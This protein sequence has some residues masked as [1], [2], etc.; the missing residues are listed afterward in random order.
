MTPYQL[1]EHLLAARR[2]RRAAE[3]YIEALARV[4]GVGVLLFDVDRSNGRMARLSCHSVA[5][6]DA[7]AV[8]RVVVMERDARTGDLGVVVRRC[9][10]KKLLNLAAVWTRSP[11]SGLWRLDADPSGETCVDHGFR[12]DLRSHAGR[13]R[14]LPPFRTNPEPH[15]ARSAG[16]VFLWSMAP[17]LRD[18]LA[19]TGGLLDVRGQVVSEGRRVGV[20][21]AQAGALVHLPVS[22]AAPAPASRPTRSPGRGCSRPGARRRGWPAARARRA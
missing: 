17:T 18:L 3:D 6:A 7:A 14:A 11:G 8:D 12:L 10:T 20:L 4:L 9:R 5:A 16:R 21:A 15:D 19:S 2:G 22:P 13:C 1:P